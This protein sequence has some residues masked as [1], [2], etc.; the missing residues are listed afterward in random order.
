MASFWEA[1][2]AEMVAHLLG[3]RET[4]ALEPLPD[5]MPVLPVLDPNDAE[6]R[7]TRGDVLISSLFDIT[8]AAG[9]FP[10]AWLAN[11]VGSTSLVVVER[12]LVTSL[13]TQELRFGH[14]PDAAAIP[15][16]PVNTATDD[17]RRPNV[18]T[19]SLRSN[20]SAV[21]AIGGRPFIV[22][23]NTLTVIPCRQVLPPGYALRLQGQTVAT[24]ILGWM[25]G[26][27]RA[28]GNAELRVQ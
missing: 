21:A 5:L 13:T 25:Q 11:P 6:T 1:R 3:T 14:G 16:G 7:L 19:R 28:C 20:E 27:E 26:R 4:H 15:G 2:F 24:R 9:Q 8:A 17:D 10:T 12:I 18:A 22:L 23:L